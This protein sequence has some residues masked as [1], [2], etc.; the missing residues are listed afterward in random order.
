MTELEHYLNYLNEVSLPELQRRLKTEKFSGLYIVEPHA[1]WI[2]E[3]KKTL[4]LKKKSYESLVGKD[5]ILC[6]SKA[7]GIIRLNPS[8]K[9]NKSKFKSLQSKHLVTDSE[10][11]K[12]WGTYNLICYPFAFYPFKKPVGYHYPTGVQTV[13][14][15]VKLKEK[16]ELRK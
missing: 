9:I 5:L 7:Y 10:A 6:G 11:I 2:F 4:V 12:W 1:K 8:K 14:K 3:R 15:V 16:P 13:I